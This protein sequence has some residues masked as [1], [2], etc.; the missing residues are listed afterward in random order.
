MWAEMMP[1]R[2]L[3][4]E[5]RR[6]MFSPLSNAL[7]FAKRF[8]LKTTSGAW[9]PPRHEE[10]Q[11]GSSETIIEAPGNP[12]RQDA[13]LAWGDGELL[14][15]TPGMMLAPARY[16]SERG[17]GLTAADIDAITRAHHHAGYAKAER[18]YEAKLEAMR[19]ELAQAYDEGYTA[20]R[21]ERA[22]GLA[23]DVFARL[24]EP[25]HAVIEARGKVKAG[26]KAGDAAHEGFAAIEASIVACCDF[27]AGFF[28]P[29]AADAPARA[30]AQVA[31][32]E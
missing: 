29:H 28:S 10:E 32:D 21:V 30:A 13:R 7:A 26:T 11:M 14:H 18:E 23:R 5:E 24:F 25:R 9:T 16:D 8:G 15:G 2:V 17:P 3:S 19:A 6:R 31:R 1:P 12:Y 4:E 20:G 27:V 22:Q